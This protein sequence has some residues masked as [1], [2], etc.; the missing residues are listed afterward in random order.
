MNV[1]DI[2]SVGNSENIKLIQK[3]SHNE[4]WKAEHV[5]MYMNILT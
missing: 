3:K 5:C 1:G 2:S 4:I